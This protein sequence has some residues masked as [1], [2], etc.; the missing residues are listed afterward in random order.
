MSQART[1]SH[2]FDLPLELREG[3]YK[4]I[5]F[6]SGTEI[7]QACREVYAEARKFLYQKPLNFQSQDVLFNWLKQA[8]QEMLNHVSDIGLHIR[9]VNLNPILDL[10]TST[11]RSRSQPRLLTSELYLAEV[12]KIKQA[13][14]K[15]PKVKTFTI[16]TLP[17]RPSYLYRDF[18]TQVLLGL[19][20]SYPDLRDL[21]LEGNFHHQGLE[22]LSNLRALESFSFNG[23]SSSSPAT[24][25]NILASLPHL[26]NLSLISDIAFPNVDA[27]SPYDFMERRRSFT[28]SVACRMSQLAS[29]SVAERVPTPTPNLF[30]TPD[31]LASLSEL[32]TLRSLSIH[33]AHSP[34][35]MIMESLEKFLGKAAIERFEIDWPDLHPFVL[36]RYR[37]LSEGLKVFWVRA[38]SEADAFEI[39]WSIVESRRCGDLSELK[40]VVLVRS[41]EMYRHMHNGNYDDEKH[42]GV[43]QFDVRDYN[44]SSFQSL[45]GKSRRIALCNPTVIC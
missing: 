1:A 28:G 9:E 6:F 12:E 38:R 8:P 11:P 3:I 21:R 45:S 7:L 40:N 13:F 23:I 26:T 36:E 14:N 10:E 32:K 25:S 42:C 35:T 39:L 16:R 37:L 18:V 22:F 43:G 2:F 30:L 17:G 5:L 31:I 29:F 20:S 33:L 27:D 41:E 44:V 15:I 19:S 24:T 34:N 4:S